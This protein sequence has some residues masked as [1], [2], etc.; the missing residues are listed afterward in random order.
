M[1]GLEFE[2]RRAL[3]R[4]RMRNGATQHGTAPAHACEN[5]ETSMPAIPPI[6][7][8]TQAR[9]IGRGLNGNDHEPDIDGPR[10][11]GELKIE[12]SHGLFAE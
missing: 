9:R 12:S 6:E 5:V 8:H 7:I 1:R 3:A 2:T 11:C 4:D 10:P